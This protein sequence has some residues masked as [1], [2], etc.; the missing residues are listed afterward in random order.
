[1]V[2][3]FCTHKPGGMKGK[4]GNNEKVKR[5]GRRAGRYAEG[6]DKISTGAEKKILLRAN[7][8]S[9]LILRHRCVDMSTARSLDS[10]EQ[11]LS[12]LAPIYQVFATQ[13]VGCDVHAGF[14]GKMTKHQGITVELPSLGFRY[15]TTRFAIF[16]CRKRRP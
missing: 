2:P 3:T 5:S 15:Y 7:I 10:A 9:L 16:T 12:D 14:R 13:R 1:M 11:S 8:L 4:V 6:G